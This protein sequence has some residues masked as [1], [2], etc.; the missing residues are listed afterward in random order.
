MNIQ[1]FDIRAYLQF[2]NT[3]IFEA[4]K[5]VT[6]GWIGVQCIYCSDDHNH[7]G[8]NLTFKG[9]SCWKCEAK[10]SLITFIQDLEN[11]N[12]GAA[13]RRIDDFQS[14]EPT[15]VE[16]RER[17]EDNRQD[18]LPLHCDDQFTAG[19]RRY[20]QGRRFD[21]EMLR[22]HWGLRAGPIYGPWKYRIIIPVQVGG[23]TM[24]WIGMS[25]INDGVR[26]KAAPVEQSFIPTSELLY[27][28]DKVQ[29]GGILVKPSVLV[30]EGVTD[31]WRIGPGAIATLGMGITED[32]LYQ[33][34]RLDAGTY[35]IMFD[36]EDE[37]A[38]NATK[39]ANALS[40]RGKQVEVMELDEGDP[41]DLTDEEANKVRSMIGLKD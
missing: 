34:L 25:T 24:T 14:L 29:K 41:D 5:G 36:G 39:L 2:T 3:P 8:I 17:L 40:K 23:R 37:A 11:I 27:G 32:K 19:Q 13:L 28:V 10:G 16:T 1:D 4:G 30:V 9:F 31:V 21:P 33:L 38:L 7:L 35:Y 20:L 6:R 12:Y 26:Y 18:I 15:E 22:V